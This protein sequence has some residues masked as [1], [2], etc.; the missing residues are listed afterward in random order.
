MV[1][2][3]PPL[4]VGV[5]GHRRIIDRARVRALIDD[6]FDDVAESAAL[7][8]WSS[9][10]EGADRIGA[11]AALDRQAALHVVLPVPADDYVLDFPD[12]TADFHAL[13]ARAASV[14]VVGRA[15]DRNGAYLEAGLQVLAST[16]LLVVAWNGQAAAGTGGTADIVDHARRCGR[17]MVWIRAANGETQP[18]TPGPDVT[19]ERVE[20]L[21]R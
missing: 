16:D 3:D 10:A 12:T 5:I 21:R 9:L 2:A 4:R 11:E 13:L 8:V 18:A 6:V 1:E 17:P 7:A 19:Y 20:G 14:R 15:A